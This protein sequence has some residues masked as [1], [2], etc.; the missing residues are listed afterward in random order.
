MR[1]CK[2]QL[3]TRALLFVSFALG[4]QTGVLAQ[5]QNEIIASFLDPAPD[6]NGNFRGFGQPLLNDNSQLAFDAGLR[7]TS[8]GFLDNQAIYSWQ[9]GSLTKVV[10]MGDAAPEG[11]GILDFVSGAMLNQ[12]GQIGFY[13][14]LR[15]TSGGFSDNQGLY[16]SD[17]NG[18]IVNIVRAGQT[19][20]DG[21]G[22]YSTFG[23]W[24]INDGGSISFQS[25][26]TNTSGGFDDRQGIFSGSGG[27][28][29]QI[30]RA[31]GNEPG[32]G[33]FGRQIGDPR[34][35]NA[36]DVA[37]KAQISNS[38]GRIEG[39][40]VSQNGGISEVVVR[41]AQLPGSTDRFNT[42]GDY[43]INNL[44]QV[45]FSALIEDSSGTP[46]G[47]GVYMY[48]NG[49][50]TEIHRNNAPQLSHVLNDVGQV[51]F[52]T[53][54]AVIR[55]DVNSTQTLIQ[56]GDVSADGNG[57]YLT[58]NNTA[59]NDIGVVAFRSVLDNTT[60]GVLDDLG[61]FVTDGID[62]IQVAREG[63]A[64]GNKGTIV[65]LE[66][67]RLFGLNNRGQLAYFATTTNSPSNV[68]LWTPTLNWRGG[69]TGAWSDRLNWTLGI[70]PDSVHD[71]NIA[72]ASSLT[73]TGP[74]GNAQIKSLSIGGNVGAARLELN[75]GSTLDV[76]NNI[77]VQSNGTIATVGNVSISTGSGF[78]NS[79]SL[80]V[81]S[82]T[83][84]VFGDMNNSGTISIGAG[85]IGNFTGDLVQNGN[86]TTGTGS[87]LTVSG[88]FSGS[89]STTGDGTTVIT[90]ELSPGNSTAS[91][92]FGTDL[93][94]DDLAM[95]TFELAGQGTGE[96]DQVVVDGNWTVDGNLTVKLLNGYTLGLGEEYLVGTATSLSGQFNGLGEGSLVGN[97]SGRD[98]FI[99]YNA[100]GGNGIALFTS[101]VPEPT[102]TAI[103][104]AGSSIVV[105][106]RRR[107]SC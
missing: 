45:S 63:E 46:I 2:K 55:G 82:G 27:G 68:V 32:S 76:A 6:G 94:L 67:N 15:N 21:N 8:G 102:G 77:S 41:D 100:N 84:S 74:T 44:G 25:I 47:Q 98:L 39:I 101:S 97:F 83:L 73:I 52:D 20:P 70:D 10:R 65:E 58:F 107:M 106:R 33:V 49:T 104:L 34:S 90:G 78:A 89:G 23:D 12:N 69:S 26:L 105:L 103:M 93:L 40:F 85:A 62:T 24:R 60:G 56:Q 57:T 43:R 99:T 75:D 31:G 22:Q 17:S 9:Q 42:L 28:I 48:D 81:N 7:D 64:L 35:N 5:G 91:I 88:V 86:L 50:L 54:I 96:F 36:G 79:G 66:F 29:S 19:A 61:L 92:L 4:V 16:R 51:A 11:N 59:I 53:G 18:A 1:S 14:T 38:P 71:V 95:T 80:E 3:I 72:S 87:V 30:V 13:S 37:V